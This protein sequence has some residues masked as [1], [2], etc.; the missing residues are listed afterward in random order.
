MYHEPLH[1]PPPPWGHHHWGHPLSVAALR[2][3]TRREMAEFD[4]LKNDGWT[5]KWLFYAILNIWWFEI[6]WV[7]QRIWLTYQ[8]KERWFS[9]AVLGYQ[10]VSQLTSSYSSMILLDIQS[11]LF[12]GPS[13]ILIGVLGFQRMTPV[14]KGHQKIN[15]NGFR[16]IWLGIQEHIIA[17]IEQVQFYY[18]PRNWTWP[19]SAH[20]FFMQKYNMGGVVMKRVCVP[21]RWT[22]LDRRSST[23]SKART[24]SFLKEEL[25]QVATIHMFLDPAGVRLEKKHGLDIKAMK[26]KE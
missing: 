9:I 19:E 26:C 21:T 5:Y 3:W 11:S 6:A 15:T 4:L 12:Q 25:S 10:Q 23:S 13:M 18:H 24:S 14:K 7:W 16:R 20:V 2:S 22:W 1:P 8:G 17:Y